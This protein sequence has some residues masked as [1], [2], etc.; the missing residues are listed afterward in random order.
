MKTTLLT[1][2]IM[3][4]SF[5]QEDTFDF[6]FDQPIKVEKRI[7]DDLGDVLTALDLART[8][9]TRYALI[10]KNDFQKLGCMYGK[11]KLTFFTYAI[12]MNVLGSS[13][14]GIISDPRFDPNQKNSD[15]STNLDVINDI[16]SS[17]DRI[18]AGN[19]INIARLQKLGKTSYRYMGTWEAMLVSNTNYKEEVIVIKNML[20]DV[21]AKTSRELEDDSTK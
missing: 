3:T 15:G 12:Q 20:I 18:I 9:S 1:I 5:A 21:G 16:I 8:L 6:W 7:C 19:H 11:E 4:S 10:K 14:K 17:T 13:H 2:L